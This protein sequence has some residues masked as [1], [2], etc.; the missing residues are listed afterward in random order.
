[1][2]R[3]IRLEGTSAGKYLDGIPGTKDSRRDEPGRKNEWIRKK[4]RNMNPPQWKRGHGTLLNQ[5]S[6]QQIQNKHMTRMIKGIAR[7]S[8]TGSKYEQGAKCS[9]N[10]WQQIIRNDSWCSAQFSC[11]FSTKS[12]FPDKNQ[13]KHT[14]H[15]HSKWQLS[16]TKLKLKSCKELR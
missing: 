1:M 11:A 9:R 15:E 16:R 13:K 12:L 2:S 14:S 7:V 8:E 10:Y 3:G 4:Q 6:I 5:D